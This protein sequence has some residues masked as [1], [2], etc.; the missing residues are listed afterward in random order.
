[1]VLI[2][3]VI[4][5]VLSAKHEGK[6]CVQPCVAGSCGEIGEIRDL[7]WASTSGVSKG[8]RRAGPRCA[9]VVCEWGV[10]PGAGLVLSLFPPLVALA[11]WVVSIFLHGGK[12]ER[13]AT[14]GRNGGV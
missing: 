2:A 1:M 8:T 5:A 10:R 4:S 12:K 6:R 11:L 14:N 9:G 3:V 13:E 7:E